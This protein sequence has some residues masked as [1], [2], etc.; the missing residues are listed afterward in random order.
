MR[1]KRS[2]ESHEKW[3]EYYR[4]AAEKRKERKSKF[5][6]IKREME[7]RKEELKDERR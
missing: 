3:N 4:R 7:Q 5:D 6:R 2:K 1:K